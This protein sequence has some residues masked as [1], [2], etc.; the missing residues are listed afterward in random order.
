M[1][2]NVRISSSEEIFR[3]LLTDEYRVNEEKVEKL[4]EDC[5]NSLRTQFF[6]PLYD[7]VFHRVV[8]GVLHSHSENYTCA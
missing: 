2:Y 4:I 7:V 3:T 5:E 1:D 8:R 6:S